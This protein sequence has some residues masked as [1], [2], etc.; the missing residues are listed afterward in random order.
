MTA[1]TWWQKP[2]RVS[3][4]VDN[5]SWILPFAE[6]VVTWSNAQGDTASLIRRHDDIEKGAVAFYLGCVKIAPPAVLARNHR[7]LVVHASDLPE[8]RGWSPLSWLILQGENQIPVCLLEG[9]EA[10]DAGPIIYKDWLLFEGHELNSE[11]RESL[12]QAHIKLCQRFLAE[13]SPPAGVPQ[14]GNATFFN[15]R[16]SSDSQ[17]N[18]NK[19]I[20]EQFN[21][22]RIVDNERYPAFFILHGHQYEIQIVKRRPDDGKN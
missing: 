16:R 12:G 3:V 5:D 14:K 11:M 15:R 21:L 13:N 9:I 18:V 8:G 20:Q 7:N 6:Q 1:P 17:L 2:R 19:T 10:L 22:L 4:V